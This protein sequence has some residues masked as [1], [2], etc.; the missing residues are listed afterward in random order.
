MTE[1]SCSNCR[2]FL[3]ATRSELG[4]CRKNPPVVLPFDW[5]LGADAGDSVE[6]LET[7]SVF[8]V[9]PIDEWCGAY[10][11]EKGSPRCANP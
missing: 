7:R 11:P 4:H 8:P 3:L 6:Q 10:E 5:D 2:Y 1:E 9:V